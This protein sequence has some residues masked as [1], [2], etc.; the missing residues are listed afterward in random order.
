[1]RRLP[2]ALV[3]PLFCTGCVGFMIDR[4]RDGLPRPVVDARLLETGRST[5]TETLARLGPP[6]VIL[7]V[8]RVNR[9]YYVSWDSD[10]YKFMISATLPFRNFSWDVF[11]LSLGSEEFRMA[12]LEFDRAGVLRDLQWVDFESSSRGQSFALDNRIVE[13]FLED[14]ARALGLVEADDDDE[15]LD[16]P[17]KK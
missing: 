16:E 2:L 7:R 17:P 6:D 15:D 4:S 12:R 13:N 3:A 1:M 14:R 10:Y 5:L 9:A 8:G 11:I